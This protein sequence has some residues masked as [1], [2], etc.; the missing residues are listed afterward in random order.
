MPPSLQRS[1]ASRTLTVLAAA[2]LAFD[3]AGLVVA[4]FWL[5]R[6][7][8]AIIGACLVVSSGF[9]FLYWRW[10]GRQLQE[11]AEA[12]RDIVAEA[13]ALRDLARRN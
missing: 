10:H 1:L 4:G 6:P 9:V 8:L 3:G 5:S 7:L 12:R 11:I 2:F 13:R